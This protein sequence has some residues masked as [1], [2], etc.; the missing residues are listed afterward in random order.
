MSRV[1]VFGQMENDNRSVTLGGRSRVTRL[2]AWINT[3]TAGGES[4][5][6]VSTRVDGR[7][8][9]KERRK[10]GDD[11]VANFHVR[12]PKHNGEFTKVQIDH[13]DD[14]VRSLEHLCG[15]ELPPGVEGLT[16]ETIETAVRE[17]EV[18]A[19]EFRH[20]TLPGGIT[21]AHALAC[22]A[23]VQ[24]MTKAVPAG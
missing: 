21:L 10:E 18:A 13:Q 14:T 8:D 22:A 23:V 11:R 15:V 9:P 16:A 5:L 2:S 24:A 1:A 6:Q 17:A 7:Q 19:R 20:V 12:L 4:G 3:D